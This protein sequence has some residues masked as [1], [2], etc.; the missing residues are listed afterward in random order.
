MPANDSVHPT[1]FHDWYGGSEEAIEH[2][3]AFTAKQN[4]MTK[5]LPDWRVA[6]GLMEP[7]DE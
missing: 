2:L 1:Q 4:E 3:K 7:Y 6:S 5:H